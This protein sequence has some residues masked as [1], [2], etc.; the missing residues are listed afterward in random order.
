VNLSPSTT[1][2]SIPGCDP[3]ALP[4]LS[5][6]I[7]SNILGQAQKIGSPLSAAPVPS[8][9]SSNETAQGSR[10]SY[11]LDGLGAALPPESPAG[12]WNF[13]RIAT[14]LPYLRPEMKA[15]SRK[16]P[17]LD[18]KPYEGTD[19]STRKK[20]RFARESSGRKLEDHESGRLE[21][22][23]YTEKNRAASRASSQKSS[24]SQ[25]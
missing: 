5:S 12:T 24:S 1:I 20:V 10:D 21:K 25:R 11:D 9:Q 4:T 18:S 23:S 16:K 15:Q 22:P 6:L 2:C 8:E 19:T 13:R 14:S 7:G 3:V 17:E